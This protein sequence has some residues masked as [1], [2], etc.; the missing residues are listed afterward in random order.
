[1]ANGTWGK[2][3]QLAS[4][5]IYPEDV[6]KLRMVLD[7]IVKEKRIKK[8]PELNFFLAI[9]GH[10]EVHHTVKNGRMEKETTFIER[11]WFGPER[12][13]DRDHVI[14]KLTDVITSGRQNLAK[15]LIDILSVN[16]DTLKEKSP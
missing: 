16:T 11:S 6:I 4:I 2:P 5:G 3:K 9:A 15:S 14:N 8:S 13:P 10:Y 1:M 12:G 7:G